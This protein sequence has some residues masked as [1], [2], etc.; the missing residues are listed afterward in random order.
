MRGQ[1]V[2]PI[3]LVG[4]PARIECSC[5]EAEPLLVADLDVTV[6]HSLGNGREQSLDAG[7]LGGRLNAN[8][9][10]FSDEG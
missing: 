2:R 7:L 4:Q 10:N 1:R 5:H 8:A 9:A 3:V 6:P